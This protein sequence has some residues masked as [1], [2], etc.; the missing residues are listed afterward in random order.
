[1][2]ASQLAIEPQPHSASSVY[3]AINSALDP[4][5]EQL[6]SLYALHRKWREAANYADNH[7]AVTTLNWWHHELERSQNQA[8]EHPA[9]R[10]LQTSSVSLPTETAETLQTLLHGHMHWHH[11]N[12]I[13]TEAQ[14][15]PTLDAIGGSFAR[16]WF[17]LCGVS[18]KDELTQS[19]G[20]ALLWTDLL[21][22]LG[23]NLSNQRIWI[24]MQWL[25]D[26]QT[27]AHILLKTDMPATDRTKQ[28]QPLIER[29]SIQAH[30]ELN[31]Y[32]TH[33]QNLSKA[34]QKALRSWHIL[35]QLRMDLLNTIMQEP[36]ELFEGLVSIA[37]LRKWWRVVRT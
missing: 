10:A 8:S 5:R 24:P 7:Q 12:R 17:E 11:L 13:D 37:P 29:I 32:Q 35:M 19:A 6:L 4:I 30:N 27:P 20:R 15:Q 26:S 2:T 9:L 25:K 16:L 23:H 1:M 33:Y 3:Y 28:L 14:L 36:S 21:R 18:S 22:H 34:Q 31:Q